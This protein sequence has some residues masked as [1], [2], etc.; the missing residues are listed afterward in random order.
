M[1]LTGIGADIRS[2]QRLTLSRRLLTV[3]TMLAGGILGAWLVLNAG[4]VAP[5]ALATFLLAVTAAGATL[6]AR[7]PGEWRAAPARP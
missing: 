4:A 3:V 1:T 5:L 2:G 7:S 6:A